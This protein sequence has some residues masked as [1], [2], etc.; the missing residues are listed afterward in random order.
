MSTA[1]AEDPTGIQFSILRRG[2]RDP[3]GPYLE[4]DL[5]ELMNAGSVSAHD[6]V[7][8]EGLGEWKPIGEVF[9]IQ[10]Q[11]SHFVDD[12]QDTEKVGQ[13]FREV[14]DI[15]GNTESIFYIAVQAKAGLL[16]KTKQCVVITEKHIY[17]LHERRVGYELEA[18]LWKT[19]TNTLMRDEGKGLGTF[20]ILLGGERRVDVCHIPLRQVQRLFQLSQEMKEATD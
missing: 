11:I 10:E 9:D 6:L 19:V 14:T 12:G 5:L 20:S 7:F 17:I 2:S 8:Y 18:H 13:A 4:H 16:S 3:E 15:V 1:P